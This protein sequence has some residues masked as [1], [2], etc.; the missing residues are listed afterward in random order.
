MRE[1]A[2]DYKKTLLELRAERDTDE[3]G[4]DRR[5]SDLR[6]QLESANSQSEEFQRRIILLE[7]EKGQL[8]NQVK[9]DADAQGTRFLRN[10]PQRD[11]KLAKIRDDLSKVQV[12]I[13][14]KDQQ[15]KSLNQKLS[16]AQSTDM[17]PEVMTELRGW[18]ERLDTYRASIEKVLNE[19]NTE[20]AKLTK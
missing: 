1:K 19:K 2:D 17:R 14:S 9:K 8:E 15:I 12:V 10:E 6:A 7:Y 16:L 4:R 18:K 3:V 13:R 5:S 11:D 20:I